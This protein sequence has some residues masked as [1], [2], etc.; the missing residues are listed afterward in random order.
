MSLYKHAYLNFL[1]F[2]NQFITQCIHKAN[3]YF[4]FSTR[5]QHDKENPI[6]LYPDMNCAASVP[7]FTLIFILLS[8]LL[9]RLLVGSVLALKTILYIREDWI[10][11]GPLWSSFWVPRNLSH[12]TCM[13][14][15]ARTVDTVLVTIREM[16]GRTQTLPWWRGGGEGVKTT[17]NKNTL[18]PLLYIKKQMRRAF[19]MV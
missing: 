1:C 14:G 18:A 6:Y 10:L 19:I 2:T 13:I 7:I 17:E 9:Y 15:P 8:V 3:S 11:R 5:S 16:T 12:H 4:L